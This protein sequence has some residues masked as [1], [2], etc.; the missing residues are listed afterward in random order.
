MLNKFLNCGE[1]C[2]IC[3]NGTEN[4]Q[5]VILNCPGLEKARINWAYPEEAD[6]W[7]E[8]DRLAWR[9][10]FKVNGN[11][12]GSRELDLTKNLLEQWYYLRA[13]GTAS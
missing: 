10:G 9:L 2:N 12:I 3:H 1:E 13:G 4:T 11:I 8:I 5:H 6:L 7:P